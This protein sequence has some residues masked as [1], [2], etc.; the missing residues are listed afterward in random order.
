MFFWPRNIGCQALAVDRADRPCSRAGRPI[1]RPTCTGLCTSGQPLGRST[2]RSTGPESS[3]L[4]FWAVDRVPPTVIFMT[5]GGRPPACLADRSAKRLCFWRSYKYPISWGVL[6]KIL[7]AKIPDFL[8][9]FK[10]VFKSVLVL[11]RSIFIC[12]RVFGK[13]KEKSILGDL[14]CSSFLSFTKSFPK[15]F[16]LSFCFPNSSFPHLS[17]HLSYSIRI[18]FC[19]KRKEVCGWNIPLVVDPWF[20]V[21]LPL[22]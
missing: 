10:Q 12:F 4:C 19:E 21:L 16:S 2:G 5:V 14:I 13:I 3:A 22:W 15:C 17:Y 7:R 1:G 6:Y 11:K 9:C 20:L 18:L 8:K